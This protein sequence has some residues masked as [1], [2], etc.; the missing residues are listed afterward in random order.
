MRSG[1]IIVREN[2]NVNE[3]VAG[4]GA[5]RLLIEEKL[6]ALLTDEVC[7]T[8]LLLQQHCGEF[9]LRQDLI[10]LCLASLV[11]APSPKMRINS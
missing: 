11:E 9:V 3:K 7:G 10:R 1:F 6:S 8:M 2:G 4:A 5:P